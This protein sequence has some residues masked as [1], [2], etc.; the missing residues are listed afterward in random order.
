ME[1]SLEVLDAYGISDIVGDLL[2]KKLPNGNYLLVYKSTYDIDLYLCS[3]L[4]KSHKEITERCVLK[5][6]LGFR[7]SNIEKMNLFREMVK[8]SSK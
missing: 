1:Q 2:F 5:Q 4:P 6:I 8:S 3:M 7:S